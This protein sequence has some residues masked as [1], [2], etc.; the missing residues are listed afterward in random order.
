MLPN[1]VPRF[2]V[3]SHKFEFYRYTYQKRGYLLTV[4]GP[5]RESNNGERE[6]E[7]IWWW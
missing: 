5:R 2:N 7:K 3:I 4:R 6:I 1:Q